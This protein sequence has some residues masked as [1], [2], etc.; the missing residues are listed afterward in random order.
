MTRVFTGIAAGGTGS[1]M[2]ADLPKQFLPLKDRP[3]LIHTTEKFASL[4]GIDAVFIGVHKDWTGYT[5]DL[6]KRFLPAYQEKVF[7][8]PGGED[9]NETVFRI[10]DA[11]EEKF[12]SIAED[13]ILT[14]DAVRPFV[15]E[16]IIA[17]NIR[18]AKEFGAVG[19]AVKTVDTVYDSAD[20][21]TVTCVPDRS[22]LYQAQTP[23]TFRIGLLKELYARLTPYQKAHLTDTCSICSVRDYPVHMAAGSYLNIKI[24][25]PEDLKIAET[26]AKELL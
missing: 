22:R 26:L 24:T 7:I 10:I 14:H 21:E 17:D 23:Q 11:I 1:R 18:L 6:I 16:D 12:G 9:R 5:E 13:I 20:G 4:D 25:T 19:T 3:I 8:L 2:G 15:T